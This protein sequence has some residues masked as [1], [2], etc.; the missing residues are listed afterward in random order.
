MLKSYLSKD[1]KDEV[2]NLGDDVD[3]IWDRLDKKYGDQCKLVDAIMTDIKLIKTTSANDDGSTLH[4]INVIERA[5]RDLVHMGMEKE[6]N[7]STIISM[8]EERMSKLRRT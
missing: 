2:D 5:H 7:N 3:K 6:I 1:I 4:M 8:I